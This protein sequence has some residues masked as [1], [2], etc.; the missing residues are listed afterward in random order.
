MTISLWK[1]IKPLWYHF[2]LWFC[3]ELWQWYGRCMMVGPLNHGLT[4]I[5]IWLVLPVITDTFPASFDW[6]TTHNYAAVAPPHIKQPEIDILIKISDGGISFIGQAQCIMATGTTGEVLGA[7][8]GWWVAVVWLLVRL[9]CCGDITTVHQD[10][11]M[12]CWSFTLSCTLLLAISDLWGLLLSGDCRVSG[13]WLI[14]HFWHNWQF[15]NKDPSC[16]IVIEKFPRI[17]L[18]L[19]IQSI[20]YK[21]CNIKQDL[22]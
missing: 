20:K 15:Q 14:N 10:N 19:F 21:D 5:M 1:Y 8:S 2:M 11:T 13:S 17:I 22:V 7:G 4:S 6:Q 12:C 18:F 16:L 9:W 3:H